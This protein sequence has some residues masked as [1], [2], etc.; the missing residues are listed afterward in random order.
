MNKPIREVGFLKAIQIIWT[1]RGVT[2]L[3]LAA[4]DLEAAKLRLLD[5]EKS[6]EV[7]DQECKM[8]QGRI[9]RL[10]AYITTSASETQE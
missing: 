8:L 1:G 6:R 3:M 4:T 7:Y 2:P 10:Q 5:M 9:R